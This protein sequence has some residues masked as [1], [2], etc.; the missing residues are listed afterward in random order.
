MLDKVQTPQYV[1]VAV[2]VKSY[3]PAAVGT[4]SSQ[5]SYPY[6]Y[7]PPTRRDNPGGGFPPSDHT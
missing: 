5:A 3:V 4:P 7:G 6:P 2:T 1:E